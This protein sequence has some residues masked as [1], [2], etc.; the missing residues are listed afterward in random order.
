MD[1]KTE[2]LTPEEVAEILKCEHKTVYGLMDQHKIAYIKIG[3][4]RRIKKEDLN[5]FIDDLAVREAK[6][7]K[8]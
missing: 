2:I 3:K 1:D 6:I 7:E 4:N 5:K 8:N